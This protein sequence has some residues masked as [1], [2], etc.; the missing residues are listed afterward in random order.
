MGWKD[1]NN[2]GDV[3]LNDYVTLFQNEASLDCAIA[4][5]GTHDVS[6]WFANLDVVTGDFCGIPDVHAGFRDQVRRAIDAP[7]WHSHMR[8]AM[9]QC[10]ELY[11]TGHSLGAA[12]AELFAAC[13]QHAPSDGEDG[14]EDYRQIRWVPPAK[15]QLIPA[16]WPQR[17]TDDDASAPAPAPNL[18]VGADVPMAP[19]PPPLTRVP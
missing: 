7:K 4:F 14:W 11:V 1:N 6:Q 13:L 16:A 18:E 17:K 12:E 10:T 19:A 5:V 15:S 2:V 3:I 9:N 8:P